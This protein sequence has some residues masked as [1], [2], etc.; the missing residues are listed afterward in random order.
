MGTGPGARSLQEYTRTGAVRLDGIYV[1]RQLSGL[2]CGAETALTAFTD[3]LAV[4][5]GTALDVAPVHRGRSYAKMDAALLPDAGV[6]ET[7]RQRWMGWRR[8]R[9]LYP[10]IVM[11]WERVARNQIRKLISEGAMSRRDDLA[12]GN[13]YHASI[14]ELL[15]SPPPTR[16][17][18]WL[19]TILRRRYS[20]YTARD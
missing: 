19:L 18:L 10:H 16:T 15:Q 1:F 12:L 9:N 6:L 8:Q 14:C 20:D 5:L 2:K 4:I 3:H 7:L 11:W 17:R 13:F